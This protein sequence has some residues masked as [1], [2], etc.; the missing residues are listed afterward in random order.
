MRVRGWWAAC[1][2]AVLAACLA[3]VAGQTPPIAAGR[4]EVRGSATVAVAACGC[5]ET[6]AA[7]R[8]A[9]VRMLHSR[10]A[11]DD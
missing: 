2:A 11:A 9:A 8:D 1:L 10:A 5:A 6:E 7:G 3:L 4:V